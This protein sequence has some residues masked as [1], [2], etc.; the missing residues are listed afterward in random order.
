MDKSQIIDATRKSVRLYREDEVTGKNVLIYRSDDPGVV[1]DFE[2]NY[3][4]ACSLYG[5]QWEALCNL[6]GLDK[7]YLS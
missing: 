1:K 7:T 3:R 4:L 6:R 5:T 2:T